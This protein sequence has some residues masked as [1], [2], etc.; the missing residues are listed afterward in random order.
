V[1]L[2]REAAL[3]V[4]LL[5]CLLA[6]ATPARAE[7]EAGG[8]F[9][10]GPFV[11]LELFAGAP[12]HSVTQ[13]R[14]FDD[15]GD[16]LTLRG[17]LGIDV[18]GEARLRIGWRFDPDDALAIGISHIFL[19][20]GARLE[21]DVHYNGTTYQGGTQLESQPIYLAPEVRYDRVLVRWGDAARAA[22]SIN[23]GVRV[24]F[25][26]WKFSEV[27]IA[28]TSTG[29]E[30][31]EDF[32]AQATPIPVLGISIR[33]PVT[34]DLDLEGFARGFR[35]NHWSSLRNEGGTIYFS[36]S[37]VEAG[38][39]LVR[40]LAPGLDL[41]IGYRYLFVDLAETSP[42]DGNYLKL[43]SHGALVGLRYQF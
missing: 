22:L 11:G 25:V 16:P 27:A 37:F 5:A 15:L 3:A 41:A 23:L 34:D 9:E 20:G 4:G 24:D 30:G 38:I 32:Y 1:V 42:E 40:R 39:G 18:V 13:V 14:E 43:E 12:G 28:P 29:K 10:S 7:G 8:A 26:D 35:A 36:E 31:R 19:W 21:H 2:T 33:L 17:D 6:I